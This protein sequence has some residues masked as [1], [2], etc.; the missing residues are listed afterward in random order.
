[1]TITETA[2]EIGLAIFPKT[3]MLCLPNSIHEGNEYGYARMDSFLYI[4][5]DTNEYFQIYGIHP[6]EIQRFFG[7]TFSLI[8]YNNHVYLHGG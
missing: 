6:E 3:Q 8:C 1:M 5:T 7:M 2:T 4:R